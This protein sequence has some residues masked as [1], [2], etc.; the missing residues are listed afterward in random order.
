MLNRISKFL[1]LFSF[2]FNANFALATEKAPE[3][4]NTKLIEK[5]IS[6]DPVKTCGGH[7]ANCDSSLDCC[8]RWCRSGKCYEGGMACGGHGTSC[9]SSLDCCDRW[10]RSGRCY[11]GGMAC[12]GHGTSCD[13]SLDCCSRW[14]RSGECYGND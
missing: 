14:C 11:E 7:G 10:C 5:W 6:G 1:L 8:E 12:G 4:Y 13:S 2:V 9:D 3:A